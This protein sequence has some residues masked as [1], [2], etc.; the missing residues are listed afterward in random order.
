MPRPIAMALVMTIAVAGRAWGVTAGTIDR[1]VD[2]LAAQAHASGAGGDVGVVA[3]GGPPKLVAEIA[4][5]LRGRL[6]KSGFRSA[7]GL[8]VGEPAAAARA[9][10]DVIVELEVALSRE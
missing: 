10:I 1:L 5:L 8:A 6:E 4:A 3:R 7:Q 9:G 2:E